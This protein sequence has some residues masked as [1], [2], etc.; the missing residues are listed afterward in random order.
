MPEGGRYAPILIGIS[1]QALGRARTENPQTMRCDCAVVVAFAGFYLEANLN[2]IVDELQQRDAMRAFLK[3]KH[4]GLQDKLA[5]FYNEFDAPRKAATSA[6][7][8]EGDI[9]STLDRRFPG[10]AALYR[11]RNDLAHG[12]VN[13]TAH[14]LS[15]TERLREQTK[16]I[17]AELY[18]ILEKW[19]TPVSHD[20]T[21]FQAIEID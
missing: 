9:T 18:A 10:F 14:S 4:P 8:F 13:S 7:L 12:I 6:E 20:T 21:F 15:E 11:F 16:E 19:G 2:H 1:W 3:R 17:A 5:W